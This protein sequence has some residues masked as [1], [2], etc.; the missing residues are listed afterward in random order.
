MGQTKWDIFLIFLQVK[1]VWRF[2]LSLSKGGCFSL[3]LTIIY[4]LIIFLTRLAEKFINVNIL[5]HY[6]ATNK[7]KTKQKKVCLQYKL[8]VREWVYSSLITLICKCSLHTFARQV[9]TI[10]EGKSKSSPL[11]A[12]SYLTFI[13]CNLNEVHEYLIN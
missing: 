2:V 4:V 7:D 9:K 11:P 6:Q 1:C 12:C 13:C 8:Y 10:F 3:F 5:R